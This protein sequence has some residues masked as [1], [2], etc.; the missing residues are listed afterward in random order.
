MHKLI[1]L[2]VIFSG[3]L[4]Q[5][6][7]DLV[8]TKVAD[9]ITVSL[10]S[11]FTPMT[12]DEINQKYI[13]YRKP[14]ALYTSQDKLTDFGVN[15]SVTQWGEDDLELL[16]SFYRSSIGNLYDDVNFIEEKIE[17]INKISFVVFEFTST[18]NPDRNA[19]IKQ[20]AIKKYT[21]LQYAIVNGKTVL[22]NFTCPAEQMEKWRQ[23]AMEIMQSV[24][25]KK[26]R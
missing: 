21:Y 16:K 23:T 12:R 2:V 5:E 10:P 24:K 22:L 15:R 18:I 3:G 4:W 6:M 7:P 25:I 9:G 19:V 11:S 14:L 1:L 13:S 26:T 20:N 17:E 8:K